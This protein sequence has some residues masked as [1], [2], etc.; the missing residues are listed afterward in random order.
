MK[1]MF[2]KTLL[3]AAIGT[4]SAGVYAADI[5]TGTLAS[6]VGVST[7]FA[8]LNTA[9][10]GVGAISTTLGAEYA[11][12][13]ILTFTFSGEALVASTAPTSIVVAADAGANLKGVTLGLIESDSSKLVYRITA[14]DGPADDSTVGVVLPITGTAALNTLSFTAAAVA[15]ARTISV[16][17]SARTGGSDLPIDTSGGDTR[18]V[19]LIVVAN[20]FVGT[21]PTPFSA[22]VDV[23]EDRESFVSRDSTAVG[24]GNPNTTQ[25]I[26]IASIAQGTYLT[27]VGAATAAFDSAATVTGVSYTLNGDF[28]WV[29]DTDANTAGIQSA[30]FAV[31]GCTTPALG[32]ITA[33]SITFTCA[34]ISNTTQVVI[35]TNAA[36]QGG[37]V[38]LPATTY[39]LDASVTYTVGAATGTTPVF[40]GTAAGAWTLNGSVINVSYMPYRSD[41]S[42]VFNLTN[43]FVDPAGVSVRAF[44]EDGSIV[45]LGNIATVEAN[46]ITN[47]TGAII[48]GLSAETGVDHSTVP[49]TTRYA[50]EI[51]TNAPKGLVELYTAFNVGS[52]PRAVVNDSNG[53]AVSKQ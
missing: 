53:G 24:L 41:I 18:S 1:H 2:R 21:I 13:D 52:T 15:A 39:T 22:V 9:V 26:V 25:D 11:V 36:G 46:S 45:N 38:V 50:L 31:T 5:R 42:Q 4:L 14:L 47:L 23:E 12:G 51:T 19:N 43:R 10:I 49:T 30:V 3:T 33:T 44:A 29:K 48:S 16:E 27:G 40:A 32:A 28:S 6:Q 8:Q 34:A 35:N 37:D 20:Q 7:E 17:F